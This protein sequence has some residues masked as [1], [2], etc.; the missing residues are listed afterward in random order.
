MA[1]GWT[2]LKKIQNLLNNHNIIRANIAC[3][4]RI[5]DAF[6]GSSSGIN[7]HFQ[8]YDN[9]IWNMGHVPKGVFFSFLQHGQNGDNCDKL[10]FLKKHFY[11][12]LIHKIDMDII[13]ITCLSHP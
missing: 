2:L 11:S 5:I 9:K 12:S 1:N 4:Q 7:G 3:C 13:T 8:F 6:L 10:M